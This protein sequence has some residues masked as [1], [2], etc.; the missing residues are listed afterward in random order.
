MDNMKGYTRALDTLKFRATDCT[1][2]WGGWIVNP[3]FFEHVTGK[4][5]WS[6]PRAIAME[7]YRRLQ[8]DIVLQSLYLPADPSEWRAH[9]TETLEG[10][11]RF[12][13]PES[14]VEYIGQ[15]PP[16]A[17]LR[18]SF[19]LE[20]E[21]LVL[22]Q[23]YLALQ[24][25]LGPDIFC[26]PRF[27]AT[28][29]TRYTD[30]GYESYLSAL[31]LYPDSIQRLF[32]HDAEQA[33]QKNAA[34]A[35]LVRQGKMEPF[36]LTGSDICGTRGP[37]VSPEMLRRLYFPSLRRSIEPLVAVS[38]DLIWHSDGYILPI[39]DDLI[40]CG[41]TGFQGFQEDTGFD[42]RDIAT[43]Q[44]HKG[45]RPILLAGLSITTVL[46]QGSVQETQR[47]VERIIDSVGAAGGLAIGTANT[48]GPDCRPEN[49]VALYRHT[50]A[51]RPT[52]AA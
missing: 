9:T 14:V 18:E 34:L 49:L 48:A 3:S 17:N 26:L 10:H 1:A 13:T 25:E 37:M 41:I 27:F 11:A 20:Q 22:E 23:D 51:Y 19:D 43:K 21:M 50:H 46:P 44:T 35:Q 16:V 30:F 42:I 33:R 8:V 45:R 52:H 6:A 47:E 39:I 12:G 7:A 38:A 24:E 36:F 31:A 15:L 2:T 32:E 5:F 28:R 29:F 40:S 4:Q